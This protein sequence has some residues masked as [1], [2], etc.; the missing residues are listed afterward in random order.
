[1]EYNRFKNFELFLIK[2]AL[3]FAYLNTEQIE[4]IIDENYD[5][6]ENEIKFIFNF[7]NKEV[8]NE[9]SWYWKIRGI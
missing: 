1:M 4:M 3:K 8:S 7:Y 2:Y 5:E 6:I 9:Q